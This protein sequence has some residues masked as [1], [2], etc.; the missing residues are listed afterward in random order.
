MTKAR[1]IKYLLLGLAALLLALLLSSLL[2]RYF[3]VGQGIAFGLL[4]MILAPLLDAAWHFCR[5][6]TEVDFGPKSRKGD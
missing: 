5:L 4:F 1:F 6:L 2:A 3:G